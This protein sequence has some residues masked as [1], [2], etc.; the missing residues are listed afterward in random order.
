MLSAKRNGADNRYCRFCPLSAGL[1]A[2]AAAAGLAASAAGAALLLPPNITRLGLR[3]KL[4]TARL[5]SEKVRRPSAISAADRLGHVLQRARI[6]G[7]HRHAILVKRDGR[8]GLLAALQRDRRDAGQALE[9][10]ADKCVLADRRV[11]LDH[12]QC[13]HAPRVVELDGD[14]LPY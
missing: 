13:D 5:M 8:R 4:F 9:F 10:E 14:N 7:Q 1:A 3:S 11:V 6:G 2:F 12:R